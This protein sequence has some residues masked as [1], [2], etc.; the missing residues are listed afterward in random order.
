MIMVPEHRR[1]NAGLAI[2]PRKGGKFM[3]DMPDLLQNYDPQ[4]GAI[5][6]FPSLERRL[7]DLGGSFADEA[8]YKDELERGDALIYTVT[9]V[10][11][12][13]TEGQLTYGISKIL[14]GKIGREYFMTKGHFHAWRA[15]AEIYIC[16]AGQGQII[17]ENESD[18]RVQMLPLLPDSVVYVPGYTAHRTANTGASPLVFFGIYPAQAGHDYASIAGRNFLHVIAD[19]D[20]KPALV[21][22]RK[23]LERYVSRFDDGADRLEEGG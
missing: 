5:N 2:L 12:S 22:R 13:P 6:G 15:A 10:E 7:S 3:V 8:A 4:T 23:Y 17:L 16:L 11:Y 20:G 9:S 18:G 21:E 1:F 14:P 19:I